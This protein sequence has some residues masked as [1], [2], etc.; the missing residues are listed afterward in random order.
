MAH[1]DCIL[2]SGAGPVGMIT[3]YSLAAQGIPVK[4]F[5]TLPDIPNDH[6]AATLQP[7]TLQMLEETGM[8]ADLL[9][10]GE[11]GKVNVLRFSRNT[12]PAITAD[13]IPAL[14]GFP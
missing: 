12:P 4:L 14:M 11:S 13:Q 5:D 10:Q 8:T 1:N 2:I 6:R 9:P 7:S 3:A